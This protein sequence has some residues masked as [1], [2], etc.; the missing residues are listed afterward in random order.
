MLYSIVIPVYNSSGM[1]HELYHRIQQVFENVIREDFELILVD[2][3]SRDG[4]LAQIKKI[5]ETD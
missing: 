2:D 1:I 5:S 4:S 3:A